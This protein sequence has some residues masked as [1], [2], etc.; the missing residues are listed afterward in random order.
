MPASIKPA[1][2]PLIPPT[3]V[4]VAAPPRILALDVAGALPPSV[5]RRAIERILPELQKCSDKVGARVVRAT[6]SIEET[7]RAV[8]VRTGGTGAACVAAE[9]ANVRTG[10]APDVG[11]V[12]VE[13]RIAFG[14]GS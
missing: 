4:A 12:S 11:E 3:T 5:V 9:L 1:S 13:V 2:A 10:V 7:R 6:F 14:G 8:A